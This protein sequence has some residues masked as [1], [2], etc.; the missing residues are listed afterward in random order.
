MELT[1]GE[2]LEQSKE[3]RSSDMQEQKHEEGKKTGTRMQMR[4]RCGKRER[5]RCLLEKSF[6]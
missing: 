3:K 1:S 4:K 5:G 2:C 6:C